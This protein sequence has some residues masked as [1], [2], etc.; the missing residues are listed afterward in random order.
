MLSGPL[1]PGSR[2]AVVGGGAAGLT[3]A[4]LLRERHAVTLFE[5]A[6]ALGG[7]ATTAVVPDGPDA[8]TPLD[9]GFMVLN[10]RNYPAMHALLAGLPGVRVAPSE[11]S[12]GYHSE[13]SGLSYALNWTPGAGTPPPPRKPGDPFLSLM[14]EIVRFMRRATRDLAAGTVGDGTLGAYFADRGCSERLVAGYLLPMGAAIWS[15]SPDDLLACPAAFVLGFYANHGMLALDDPPR[16]QHVAGGSRTYVAAIRE[17]LQGGVRV[18]TPVRA[19]RREAGG[20]E[21]TTD[22]EQLAFDAVVLAVHADQALALLA[23]ATPAE[24]A[25][26][27]PWRYQ[28]NQAVLH[29]DAALMPPDPGAWAAWNFAWEPGDAP[30]RGPTVTYHLNRLQG[31]MGTARP[32][33]LSLNPRRAVDPAAVLA[34]YAFDHPTYDAASVAIQPA[35]R[36]ANGEGRTWLAGS[37]FGHGFHEDAI[38]SGMAVAE[39]LGAAVPQAVAP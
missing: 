37:Y 19:V 27:G 15:A 6:P 31:L 32:Y 2:V 35:L 20:V 22:D 39:A 28:R 4:Y 30:G 5:A 11:M 14:G 12:F 13:A 16:W 34:T 36:A 8:G 17:A 38:R 26:L 24:R 1:P 29:H 33:F 3:A 10:D 9:V 23:D 25:R 21:V 18:A 7:H